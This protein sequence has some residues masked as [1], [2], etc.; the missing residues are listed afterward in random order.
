MCMCIQYTHGG[1]T[2]QVKVSEKSSSNAG[3]GVS[4][5][6][7]ELHVYMN[8]INEVTVYVLSKSH[9]SHVSF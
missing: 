2:S 5:N 7:S 3:S 9:L 4:N 8:V 6:S 1:F